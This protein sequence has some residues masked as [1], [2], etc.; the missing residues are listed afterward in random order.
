MESSRAG[1][2]FFAGARTFF[3]SLDAAVF[4]FARVARLPAASAVLP[5]IAT[6]ERITLGAQLAGGA[7]LRG[8]SQISHPPPEATPGAVRKDG[9]AQAF[10]GAVDML[11]VSGGRAVAGCALECLR[12]LGVRMARALARA[13]GHRGVLAR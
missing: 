5:A 11:A 12:A 13:G 7:R 3:C 6:E 1:N 4:L 8:Q 2:F 10:L 9:V